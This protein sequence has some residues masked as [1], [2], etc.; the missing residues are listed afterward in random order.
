MIRVVVG[1]LA[2]QAVDGLMR[3]VRS[4]LA[5]V[6]AASRDIAAAAGEELEERLARLGALPL[7]GA[8]LTPAGKLPAA[9]LI[10]VVVMSEEEPQTSLSVQRALRNGLRRAADWGLAS[11]ALPPLGLSVGMI[12]PEDSAR[13]LV[14]I[15]FN[16]L[17]EGAAPLDLTIVVASDFEARLF[18]GLVDEMTRARSAARN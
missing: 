12:E 14:E 9:Y 7:G 4:D 8:V 6:S 15:L 16:H 13:A 1:D 17:D 18:E 5:P 2:A 10:H 11:L 3:P